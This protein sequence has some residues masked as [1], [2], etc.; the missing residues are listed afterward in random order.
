MNEAESLWLEREPSVDE[1]KAAFEARRDIDEIDEIVFCGF[2]EPLERAED[3]I[4]LTNYFKSKNKYVR[5]NTN[6]LVRLIHP[7]FKTESLKI[8]DSVSI[9]LNADDEEEYLRVTRPKFGAAAYKEMLSFAADAKKY[10]KV[11]FSIVGILSQERVKK[12]REIADSLGVP[13]RIR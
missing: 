2:G 10:T 4:I 5:I 8:A 13:L 11:T 3:V 12:C 9:S 1:V 7:N 6:G